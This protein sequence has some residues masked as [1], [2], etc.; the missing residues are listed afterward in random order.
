MARFSALTRCFLHFGMLFAATSIIAAVLT[1]SP[2][3]FSFSYYSASEQAGGWGEKE[4]E[5]DNQDS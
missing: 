5:G 2:R 3:L 1:L 4:L